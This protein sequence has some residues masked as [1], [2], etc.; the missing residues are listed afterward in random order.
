MTDI[1]LKRAYEAPSEDDGYRVLVDKLWPRGLTHEKLPYALWEKQI[2][3][4]DQLREW[5]HEDREGRW[6]EFAK[7][8]AQEL[9]QSP[10]MKEFVAELAKYPK[11]TL[12]YGSHDPEHN[13][14]VVIRQVAMKMLG[15]K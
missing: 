10:Q 3:P 9:M 13:Q 15:Q 7:K 6:D 8:Y 5:F 2:A 11:V 12:L 14:A 1:V 4:S